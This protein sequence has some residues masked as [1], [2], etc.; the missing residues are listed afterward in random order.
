MTDK[1]IQNFEARLETAEQ[2]G[3]SPQKP[4]SPSKAVEKSISPTHNR[5]LGI[6]SEL[7]G[8]VLVGLSLG[9]LLDYVFK[10]SHLFLAIMTPFGAFIGLYN[11]YR[12]IIKASAAS[13]TQMEN[14][15]DNDSL[16]KD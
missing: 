2:K 14:K 7:L 16:K 5:L 6:T 12:H 1:E 4:L 13:S 11:V 3:K 8:G 10:T 15:K 9:F